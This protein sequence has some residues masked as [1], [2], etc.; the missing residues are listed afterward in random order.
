[1][2]ERYRDY[3]SVLLMRDNKLYTSHALRQ[4]GMQMREYER[5]ADAKGEASYE[6]RYRRA[7]VSYF[8]DISYIPRV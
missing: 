4:S 5:V 7:R 8:D 3:A 6:E 1:M 2:Q